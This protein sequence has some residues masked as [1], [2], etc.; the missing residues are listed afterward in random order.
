MPSKH[1]AYDLNQEGDQALAY[2]QSSRSTNFESPS[3][4]E[5]DLLLQKGN[6]LIEETEALLSKCE[7]DRLSTRRIS[8]PSSSTTI[9]EV[10]VVTPQLADDREI[11]ILLGSTLPCKGDGYFDASKLTAPPLPMTSRGGNWTFF[12]ERLHRMLHEL[13][14]EG[15]DCIKFLCHGRAFVI[16]DRDRLER[17]IPRFFQGQHRWNSF[18]RQLNMYGFLKVSSGIDEGAF[19]HSL[20][21]RNHE[22]LTRFMRRVGKQSASCT[23]ALSIAN[24]NRMV[25]QDP[26]FYTM[27]FV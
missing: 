19:Y 4:P 9:R 1:S 7:K 11:L 12:P 24:V 22:H 2:K 27:P 26:S 8:L 10:T 20:F 13:E 5:L 25:G 3:D 23:S 21:L 6:I 17:C 15:N 14:R 18:C 16:L